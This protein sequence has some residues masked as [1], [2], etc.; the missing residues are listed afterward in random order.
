M[1]LD[2]FAS[3]WNTQLQFYLNG[4]RICIPS[5]VPADMTLLQWLRSNGTPKKRRVLDASQLFF[6]FF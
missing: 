6:E 1:D 3:T 4:K 2:D 5:N